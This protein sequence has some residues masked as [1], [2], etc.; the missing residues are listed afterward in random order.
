MPVRRET[1]LVTEVAQGGLGT[2]K[3]LLSLQIFVPV[4]VI[5]MNPE[6]LVAIIR[7]KIAPVGLNRLAV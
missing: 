4:E 6:P 7:A 3:S 2:S 1:V 5:E